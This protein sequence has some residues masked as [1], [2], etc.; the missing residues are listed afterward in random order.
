VLID[1]CTLVVPASRWLPAGDRGIPVG[2]P[3]DVAGTP[4]DFRAAR[5]VGKAR[6]DHALT[7][8]ARDESGRAWARLTG[9]G[10]QVSLWAGAGYGWFQVFTGDTLP[11]GHRRT[12]LAV[13]PMTCPPNALATGDD[14]IMLAP[15]ASVTRAWGITVAPAS[16]ADPALAARQADSGYPR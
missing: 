12:A 4:L 11:A 5:P 16:H 13:E 8:L 1:E 3:R 2:A 10:G 14:L 6:L 9:G 7:G 15:G